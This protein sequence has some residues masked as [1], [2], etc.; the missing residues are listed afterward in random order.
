VL[1]MMDMIWCWRR[2]TCGLRGRGNLLLMLE[3]VVGRRKRFDS[4][5]EGEE[6][7]EYI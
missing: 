1:V 4:E 3:F 5:E 6:E 7:E 2:D